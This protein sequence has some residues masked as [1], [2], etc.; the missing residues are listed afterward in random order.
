MKELNFFDDFEEK[1]TLQKNHIDDNAPYKKYMYETYDEELEYVLKIHK[2]TPK[3]IWTII[4][5][6]EGWEGVCAG[7][8]FVNRMGYLITKEEWEDENET[9]TTYDDQPIEQM[10]NRMSFVT[11]NKVFG[12]DLFSMTEDEQQKTLVQLKEEWDDDF[13]YGYKWELYEMYKDELI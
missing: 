13:E 3:R 8:H 4:N 7:Y 6:N 10:F 2:E 1:Y 9:Y 12:V 5:N 11:L